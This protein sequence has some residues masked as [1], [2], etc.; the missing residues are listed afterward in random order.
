MDNPQTCMGPVDSKCDL[1]SPHDKR[2][3]AHQYSD[4][5]HMC[6]F[7]GHTPL[8]DALV[9]LDADSASVLRQKGAPVQPTTAVPLCKAAAI[10][11]FKFFSLLLNFNIDVLAKVSLLLLSKEVF[12]HSR[13]DQLH[14]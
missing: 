6:L 12:Q 2:H 5:R 14:L 8:W 3:S 9:Q 7:R 11:N 10:N 1:L 4:P 13:A